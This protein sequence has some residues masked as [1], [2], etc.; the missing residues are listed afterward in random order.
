MGPLF[1]VFGSNLKRLNEFI[2]IFGRLKASKRVRA[3]NCCFLTANFDGNDHGSLL[4][5]VSS[6]AKALKLKATALA[7][8]VCSVVKRKLNRSR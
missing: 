3:Q 2:Y 7:S 6:K 8:I 4:L 5:L 1:L